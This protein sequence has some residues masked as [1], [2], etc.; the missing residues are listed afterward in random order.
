MPNQ[1]RK[2]TDASGESKQAE[3]KPKTWRGVGAWQEDWGE[4]YTE[5]RPPAI[6][7]LDLKRWHVKP[8]TGLPKDAS[9][10]QPTWTPDGGQAAHGCCSSFGSY[11]GLHKVSSGSP[12]CA[13]RSL[14]FTAWSHQAS[15][16]P[17]LRQRLGIVYCMNRQVSTHAVPPVVGMPALQMPSSIWWICWQ[18]LHMWALSCKT[19]P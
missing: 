2:D 14:V 1:S 6:F 5:K 4:L 10:G 12:C 3:A 16:F 17:N 19:D 11:T 9:S 13:G 15:N 8:V 7:V 18:I